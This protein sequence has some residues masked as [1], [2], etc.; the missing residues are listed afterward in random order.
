MIRPR[1]DSA[2]TRQV[3]LK[4]A[5]TVLRT[6]GSA[7]LT[8][9]SVASAA[10]VSKG[11][12]LYHFPTK[13]TLV[14]GVVTACVAAYEQLVEDHY[15]RQAPGPGRYLAAFVSAMDDAEGDVQGELEDSLSLL[16][17]LANDPS[18]VSLFWPFIQ[19]MRERALADGIPAERALAVMAAV[20]GLWMQEALGV[21][22][23]DRKVRAGV[24]RQ[25]LTWARE[26][27]A[28]TLDVSTREGA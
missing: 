7:A 11:G 17:I 15:K 14:E 3:L 27:T 16:A 13:R 4:A 23:P 22:L 12:I 2:V 1:S 21:G 19:R 9:D 5:I 10:K 6:H 28:S 26:G 20:D 18:L 25:L 24:V 8:L